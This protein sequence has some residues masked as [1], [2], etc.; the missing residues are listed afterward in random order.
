[1]K[2]VKV[3]LIGAGSNSFGPGTINSLFA[4]PELR[5]QARLSVV[6]VDTDPT[7]LET[8]RRYGQA[9]RSYRDFPAEIQATTNR[10]EALPGANFV[11][12]AVSVKRYELWRQDFLVPAAYGVKHPTG[13]CGGPGA[14]FH[15]LRSLK[16]VVP[17]AR[18][19]ERLCPEAFLLNFTNPESR[20]CLGVSRLTSIRAAGLCHGFHTT[21]GAVGQILGRPPEE[22]ELDLG[23]LNH[24]HWVLGLRDLATGADL[25]PEFD[26]RM[27]EAA[28]GLPPL[29]RFL[30]DTF[31]RLPFPS[32]DHIGEYVG[33][34]YGLLGP[35]FVRSPYMTEVSS[36]DSPQAA[37]V[38]GVAEG[39]VPVTE[40]IAAGS[41]EIAVPIIA[42]IALDRGLRRPSV[43]VPNVGGAIANLPEDAVV[44]V[45]AVADAAGLHPVSLGLLPEAIAA[46]CQLQVSIQKLL[47]EA[48]ATGSKDALYQALL[49][50]PTVDDSRRC[51][52]MM[53]DLLRMQAE[54]LPELR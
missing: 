34:A 49:L 7:A 46:L 50:E 27:Q 24:F 10:V 18:D 17:I 43:N 26:R 41:G 2:P 4:S 11:V 47:V 42:D 31:G 6:L 8:M 3:V 20:V 14:A 39:S 37:V 48:Y 52:E 23:G 45:P 28:G 29:T 25:L 1:M 15:T 35:H 12:T 30:Y 22:L 19:M 51:R 54:Y 53:E 38:R 21:Y 16:L 36:K 32:D 13:E 44:E 40:Q 5:E 33:S 9:V